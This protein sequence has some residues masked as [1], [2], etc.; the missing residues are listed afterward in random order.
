[1]SAMRAIVAHAVSIV[2]VALAACSDPTFDVSIRYETLGVAEEDELAPRVATLTVSVVDAEAAGT[3]AGLTHDATC[4]D[5]AFGRIPAAVLEGARR[6]SVGALDTPRISG[7]PRLG[8]KLVIAEARN[9]GGRRFG[10]GCKEVGDVESDA[11]VEV[12]VE[13]APR[14]R[15]FSR[16]EIGS[17]PSSLQLV[18]TAPW[19]DVLPLGGR[20][21]VAELHS[22]SGVVEMPVPATAASGLT[23]TPD[24]SLD[25]PGPAQTLVRVRWADEPLRVPAF[26]QWPSMG[27]VSGGDHISL[28]ADDDARLARSWVS[29]VSTVNG[30]TAWGAAAL[31]KRLGAAD[32]EVVVVRY[33]TAAARLVAT[34]I[35]TPGARALGLWNGDLFTITASGWQ[36]VT[37]GGLVAVSGSAPGTGAATEIHTFDGCD[38]APGAGLIVRRMGATADAFTAYSAPGVLAPPGDPLADLVALIDPA[39]DEIVGQACADLDDVRVRIVAT[40][41]SPAGLVAWTSSGQR[42][43]L[44]GVVN[45]TSFLR[46]GTAFVA[47]VEGTITGPRVASYKLTNLLIANMTVTGFVAVDAVDTELATLPLSFVVADLDGDDLHDVIAVLPGLLGPRLQASFGRMVAGEQLA[48]VS[49]GLAGGRAAT[50]PILQLA[51]VDGQGRKEL[52]VMTDEGI[53][54]LCFDVEGMECA[55]AP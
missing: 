7:V 55:S 19:S 45:A 33:N 51:E 34:T 10:A 50:N 26:V 44:A 1:M 36:R 6:A 11:T 21:V 16:D 37:A 38:G 23:R 2:G 22:S 18:V 40:R 4:D 41:S 39:R 31:Q 43:V 24:F 15:V 20:R 29:G 52:V 46:N 54:V 25:E 27:V 35:I 53:D 3:A 5:V 42:I 14:V 13:V 8:A 47:G 9:A 30:V 28:A 32:E 12:L 48:S 17:E 49:P